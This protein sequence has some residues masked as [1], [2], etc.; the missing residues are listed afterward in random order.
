ME[1]ALIGEGIFMRDFTVP[2]KTLQYLSVSKIFSWNFRMY[3]H[4][5]EKCLSEV[6]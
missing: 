4:K 6:V 3:T 5:L 2:Y 1:W